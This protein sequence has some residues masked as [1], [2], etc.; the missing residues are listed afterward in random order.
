[1]PQAYIAVR[2]A[3][4]RRGSQMSQLRLASCGNYR[5]TSVFGLSLCGQAGESTWRRLDIG[6]TTSACSQ[7]RRQVYRNPSWLA[8]QQQAG[9]APEH[10]V[11]I[12][13][14]ATLPQAEGATASGP[15]HR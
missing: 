11:K 6:V 13:F 14:V 15:A 5:E 7:Q 3:V 2:E 1:M 10:L 4:K 9:E 12:E 8:F